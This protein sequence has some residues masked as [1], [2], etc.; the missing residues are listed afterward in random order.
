MKFASDLSLILFC[1]KHLSQLVGLC[2]NGARGKDKVE[3]DD[4]E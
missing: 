3:R 4:G 2:Q 1:R